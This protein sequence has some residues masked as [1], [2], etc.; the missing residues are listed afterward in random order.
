MADGEASAADDI[1]ASGEAAAEAAG[2]ADVAVEAV[3]PP[4]HAA[5]VR[6]K[7]PTVQAIVMVR[8]MM[9]GSLRLLVQDCLPA[10]CRAV[11]GWVVESD[12]RSR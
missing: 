11:Q 6:A 2:A 7:A 5:V 4:P 10:R 8:F 1:P 3:D 9:G 12:V